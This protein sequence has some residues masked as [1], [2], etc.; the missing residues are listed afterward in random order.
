MTWS[1]TSTAN[2]GKPL[3]LR[4]ALTAPGKPRVGKARRSPAPEYPAAASAHHE[5]RPLEREAHPVANPRA[6]R[7]R[8]L[9]GGAA[10]SALGAMARRGR[11]G[12]EHEA[13]TMERAA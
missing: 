12:D 11:T 8:R 5:N 3:G 6:D 4:R 7:V 13:A 9:T 1:R 10:S 2:I